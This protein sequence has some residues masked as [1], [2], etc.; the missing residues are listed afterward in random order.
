MRMDRRSFLKGMMALAGTAALTTLP[1]ADT[2][3]YAVEVF[4]EK[5]K[6]DVLEELKY[7]RLGRVKLNERWFPLEDASITTSRI[8][9]EPIWKVKEDSIGQY[10][11]VAGGQLISAPWELELFVGEDPEEVWKEGEISFEID[12]RGMSFSGEGYAN[13]YATEMLV[14]D[15]GAT[16]LYT[17]SIEGDNRLRRI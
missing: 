4:A 6:T 13:E 17:F 11:K 9:S 8:Y 3:E 14:R 16:I 5:G 2:D 7:G 15:R 12:G 10:E 1:L